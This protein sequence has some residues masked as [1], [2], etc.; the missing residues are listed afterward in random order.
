MTEQKKHYAAIP[1]E[2]CAI[3]RAAA[4][5][6][7]KWNLLIL[8]EAIHGVVRFDQM[9][10]DLGI[11]RTLLTTRLK[12]LV[13]EGVFE[14]IPVQ[15]PGQRQYFSYVFTVKGQA[16]LPTLIALG[17]WSSQ[18]MPG[19]R[20]RLSFKHQE[21]GVKVKTHLVCGCENGADSLH[22]ERVIRKKSK[23]SRSC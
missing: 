19:P 3:A 2:E 9:Q 20:S 15:I 12:K 11:S 1:L 17:E 4:L 10:H 18:H 23:R 14:K 21:C 6:G 5:L 8:R 22:L 7:D 16:L 13:E